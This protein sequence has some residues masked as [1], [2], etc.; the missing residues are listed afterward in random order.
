MYSASSENEMACFLRG[1]RVGLRLRG[2]GG[3][4]LRCAVERDRKPFRSVF[5]PA[6]AGVTGQPL[7]SSLWSGRY[8]IST[9]TASRGYGTDGEEA[10][11]V[12][13]GRRG[14]HVPRRVAPTQ[15]Q[16]PSVLGRHERGTQG[17]LQLAEERGNQDH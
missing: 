6:S 8:C 17:T 2:V 13:G 9:A 16:V 10:V 15:L 12:V 4:A 3:R 5:S 14:E 1:S 7:P 11:R